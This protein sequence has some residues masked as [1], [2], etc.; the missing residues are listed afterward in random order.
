M[1]IISNYNHPNAI[2]F[3]IEWSEVKEVFFNLGTENLPEKI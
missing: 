2:M 1:R 3:K